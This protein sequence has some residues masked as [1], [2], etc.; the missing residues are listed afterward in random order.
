MTSATH[1]A[2]SGDAVDEHV[3]PEDAIAFEDAPSDASDDDGD[4]SERSYDSDADYD[5]A[6]DAVRSWRRGLRRGARWERGK[7]R[8][9]GGIEIVEI[10]G[11]D[12]RAVDP[13]ERARATT[14]TIEG[15]AIEGERARE[16]K[17]GESED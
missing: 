13:F 17:V 12:A 3:D 9:W 16:E 4:A 2:A 10:R 1:G 11:D 14:R 7:R 5:A 8:G 6:G 15:W